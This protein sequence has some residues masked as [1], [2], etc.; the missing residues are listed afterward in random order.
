MRETI[1]DRCLREHADR[2]T[3]CWE[4][5]GRRQRGYGI[6]NRGRGNSP[7]LAHRAAYE[8]LRGPIAPGLH[9]DHL[10]RNPACVNPAHMEPVTQAENTRRGNSPSARRG[11]QTHCIRGHPF[12][13]ANTRHVANGRVCRTCTAERLARKRAD[14]QRP[15]P[16]YHPRASGLRTHCLRG[17]EF[18]PENTY[19]GTR[20]GR[21]VRCCRACHNAQMRRYNERQAAKR[22][23]RMAA[24]HGVVP[25]IAP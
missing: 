18:T 23:A 9:I 7:T 6:V 5:P 13:E 16:G 3:D 20:H 17:H 15:Y 10:C 24:A 19:I 25:I 14:R 21:P 22:A 11:R 8:M 4:Y 12:D 1:L 2:P